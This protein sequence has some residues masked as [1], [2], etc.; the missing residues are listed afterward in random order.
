MKLTTT[1]IVLFL[2][3]CLFA[4]KHEPIEKSG[5]Q[6]VI[7]YKPWEKIDL[8]KYSAANIVSSFATDSTLFTATPYYLSFWDKRQNSKITHFILSWANY[9][10][11]PNPIFCE[12]IVANFRDSI[13]AFNSLFEPVLSPNQN[14]WLKND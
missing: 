5:E 14:L 11:N 13:L 3:V 10:H 2:L 8:Y 9:V 6:P 12:R 7:A 1:L 4:C